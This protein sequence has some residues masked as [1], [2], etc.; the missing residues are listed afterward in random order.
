MQ[1]K[2]F[3]YGTKDGFVVTRGY[4]SKALLDKHISEVMSVCGIEFD[5]TTVGPANLKL[6]AATHSNECIRNCRKWWNN[7]DKLNKILFSIQQDIFSE[8]ALNRCD[9]NRM[10]FDLVAAEQLISQQIG[11]LKC[12]KLIAQEG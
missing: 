6:K 12:S 2:F 8:L 4:T 7:T 10:Y 3:W 11:E 5:Y 9:K 1:N